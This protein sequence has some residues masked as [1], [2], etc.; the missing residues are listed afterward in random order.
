MTLTWMTG[1]ELYWRTMNWAREGNLSS[2]SFVQTFS[3]PE[4]TLKEK[5]NDKEN[6][7]NDSQ[8]LYLEK[9]H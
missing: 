3:F 5:D 1:I 4:E 9:R 7:P 6:L 8:S 2:F